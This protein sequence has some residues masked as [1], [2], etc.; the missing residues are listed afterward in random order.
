MWWKCKVYLSLL[1][2]DMRCEMK[3]GRVNE[4]EK[5]P[6]TVWPGQVYMHL[7]IVEAPFHAQYSHV[8]V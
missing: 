4:H 1:M 2:L 3:M 6:A 7:P 5:Y 8:Q